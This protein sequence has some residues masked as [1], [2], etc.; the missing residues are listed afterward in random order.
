MA[1]RSIV[2]PGQGIGPDDLNKNN[3]N[4]QGQEGSVPPTDN[5]P[6][7]NNVTPTNNV[8]DDNVNDPSTSI[9][10]EP[11]NPDQLAQ[12]ASEV[13]NQAQETHEFDN[14]ASEDGQGKEVPEGE[15]Q[16]KDISVKAKVDKEIYG[17]EYFK[18]ITDPELKKQAAE[19][20]RDKKKEREDSRKATQDAL[21]GEVTRR[22]NLI[23]GTPADKLNKLTDFQ[24]IVRPHVRLEFFVVN[25][26]PKPSIGVKLD[27][28]KDSKGNLIPQDG[29]ENEAT[30]YAS[31]LKKKKDD[32]SYKPT[33]AEKNYK[34]S[35]IYEFRARIA[36][37]NPSMGTIVGAVITMPKV[38]NKSITLIKEGKFEAL[39][40]PAAEDLLGER[41][42]LPVTYSELKWFIYNVTGSSICESTLMESIDVTEYNGV[43]DD[44]KIMVT[45]SMTNTRTE[46]VKTTDRLVPNN[47]NGAASIL[48]KW[49]I[50]PTKKYDVVSL[51][52]ADL[53]TRS[54]YA[55]A[56]EKK[57]QEEFNKS[58]IIG[59]NLEPTF[60][61]II[62]VDE[63]TKIVKATFLSKSNSGSNL[64]DAMK[65][66]DGKSTFKQR[67]WGSYTLDKD[68]KVVYRY[69]KSPKVL[70]YTQE[71]KADGTGPKFTPVSKTLGNTSTGNFY[72]LDS[73]KTEYPAAE[74]AISLGITATDLIRLEKQYSA[75]KAQSNARGS[76]NGD[77]AKKTKFTLEEVQ[78]VANAALISKEGDIFGNDKLSEGGLLA[79]L[80]GRL[81][82]VNK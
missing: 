44:L 80:S 56:I 77:K 53:A 42:S 28:K 52:N 33:E 64:A 19:E 34:K 74:L 17:V 71:P 2:N 13:K 8:D 31:Y 7:N 4:T 11:L 57:L 21:N 9:N 62:S 26:T 66:K 81:A 30:A 46:G 6:E 24:N 55:E 14:G 58:S 72:S 50:I 59:K 12:K 61:S 36:V 41:I 5:E 65:D 27:Y 73:I 70:V 82:K 32:T 16:Y 18:D 76:K 60:K 37:T 47:R 68:K 67:V 1:R 15:D 38:I 39:D 45:P 43:V 10:E 22:L 69:E 40:L 49:N 48:T 29:K 79:T 63:N 3:T 25:G 20:L 23:E 51:D 35:D 78:E 75:Q 54:R